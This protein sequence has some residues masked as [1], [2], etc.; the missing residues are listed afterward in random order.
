MHYLLL[1]CKDV[2]VPWDHL[3]LLRVVQDLR[4]AQTV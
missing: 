3:L 1:P 2:V 4:A